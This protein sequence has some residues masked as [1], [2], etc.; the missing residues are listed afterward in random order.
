M[1]IK[2]TTI[3]GKEIVGPEI[4]PNYHGQEREDQLKGVLNICG[5]VARQVDNV[6]FYEVIE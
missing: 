4:Q 3:D 2:F 5:S 6:V 1:K